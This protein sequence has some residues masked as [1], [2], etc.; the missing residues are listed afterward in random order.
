MP[1][2][3]KKEVLIRENS[4]ITVQGAIDWTKNWLNNTFQNS[5][6]NKDE[7]GN[8]IDYFFAD[9]FDSRDRKLYRIFSSAAKSYYHM[10][11]DVVTILDST[12]FV[13]KTSVSTSPDLNGEES[14]ILVRS[15]LEDM[16]K[17]VVSKSKIKN[18]T[19]TISSENKILLDNEPLGGIIG[20]VVFVSVANG[21]VDEI[22]CL[23]SGKEITLLSDIDYS[24]KD[25]TFS[26][27]EF[28]V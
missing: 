5:E 25:A 10:S 17:N 15:A 13:K 28:S 18:Q 2:L 7:N 4:T 16:I 3:Y 27:L 1:A 14:E 22:E 6:E 12:E 19:K 20:G 8:Y 11:N 23:L 26:Y 21:V 24:G 9:M